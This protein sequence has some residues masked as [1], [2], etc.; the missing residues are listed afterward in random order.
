MQITYLGHAGFLAESKDFLL[1][2]DPWLSPHG[3]FDGAW[4]QFPKNH[5]LAPRVRERLKNFA[6]AKYIYLSHAHHDHFD[7]WNPSKTEASRW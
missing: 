5:H 2:A 6:G 3:A 1:V 7:S 4:F